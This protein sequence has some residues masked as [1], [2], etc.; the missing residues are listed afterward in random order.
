MSES[1]TCSRCKQ[2]ISLDN[3]FRN[4]RSKDGRTSYCKSCQVEY[5]RKY[6]KENPSK[7]AQYKSRWKS[8]NPNYDSAYYEKNRD[9]LLESMAEWRKANFEKKAEADRAWALANKDKVKVNAKN[10]Y[11][12]HPAKNS[13]NRQLRRARLRNARIYKVR[14][15]DLLKILRSPCVYCGSKGEQV[16]HIIPLS[17]GGS[18]SIGNLTSSCARCNLTKNNKFVAEWKLYLKGSN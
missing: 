2:T 4:R 1:K 8:K 11:L 18:H 16:D 6:R 5:C 7:E 12:R 14:E 10:Y 9:K 15:K 13:Q 17:R 3:F